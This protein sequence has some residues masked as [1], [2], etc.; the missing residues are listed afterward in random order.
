LH[1]TGVNEEISGAQQHSPATQASL[2]IL[3]KIYERYCSDHSFNNGSY[4]SRLSRISVR[5]DAV[6]R[7][8][9]I[10]GQPPFVDSAARMQAPAPTPP[11]TCKLWARTLSAHLFVCPNQVDF[12]NPL[13]IPIEP[14]ICLFHLIFPLMFCIVPFP[15]RIN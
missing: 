4:T 13:S 8:T 2:S 3:T 1:R 15:L 6:H 12:P 5:C 14:A 11:H 9:P 7:G 10:E